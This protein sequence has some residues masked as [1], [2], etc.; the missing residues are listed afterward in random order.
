MKSAEQELTDALASLQT[1]FQP[2][3]L[4]YLASTTKAEATFRDRLAFALHQ[5]CEA[6]GVIVAREWNR[7]DLAIL[8]SDGAPLCLV[9]LKLMYTFDALKGVS[10]WTS[11]TYA[12][13]IKAV[14]HAGPRT[15]VYSLLLV[16]HLSGSVEHRF[17]KAVKYSGGINRAILAHGDAS[18]VQAEAAR[19]IDADLVNRNVV[20]RGEV[21][22]G[23]AFG[24]DLSIFYWLV[25]N[26]RA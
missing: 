10:W 12:D 15:A 16:T 7:V 19:A 17:R 25:R 18:A 11:K 21:V 20:A 8:S 9:E 3:E 23:S 13:E 4:A 14:A 2:N 24:V 26:N 6:T 5:S 1:R 22:G